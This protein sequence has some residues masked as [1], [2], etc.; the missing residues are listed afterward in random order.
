MLLWEWHACCTYQLTAVMMTCTRYIADQASQYSNRDEL[1]THEALPLAEELLA[2]DGC[3]SFFVECVVS[4][5]LTVFQ[6]MITHPCTYRQ[7]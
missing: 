4:G 5:R 1:R 3:W 7:N 2:A 6:W